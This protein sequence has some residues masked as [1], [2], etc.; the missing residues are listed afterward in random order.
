VLRPCRLGDWHLRPGLELMFSPYLVHR[1]PRWWP[2]PE[3][4]R[5][6]RW[7]EGA[8]PRT[9]TAYFPF[10]AGPRACV[11]ARMATVQL[12]AATMHLATA[13]RIEITAPA[14]R[15]APGALLLPK[16]LHARFTRRVS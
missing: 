1:D 14:V 2:E 8:G 10:G 6:E 3:Q 7:L 5:V 13:Y 11:G 16:G 4:F 12:V 15:T 9:G